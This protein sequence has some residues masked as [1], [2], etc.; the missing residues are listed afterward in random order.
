[1][2]LEELL[3]KATAKQPGEVLKV[4]SEDLNPYQLEGQLV[5]LPQVAASN[6][7]DTSRFNVD[8]LISFFQSIDEPHKLLL[9]EIC[10][11]GKLLLVIPATNAASERSFSALKRQDIFACNNWR[12]KA[13]PSHDASCPQ[14][15][16]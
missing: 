15:Q 3:L 5:L 16:D 4:Y 6:A 1:M 7:F 13:E 14:G 8:D 9:S 10:M 11:L 2:N 12:R